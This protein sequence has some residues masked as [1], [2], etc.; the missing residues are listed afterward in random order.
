LSTLIIFLTV[1][2]VVFG[3]GYVVDRWITPRRRQK[4]LDRI[5]NDVRAG[6]ATRRREHHFTISS[7]SAGFVVT[8]TKATSENPVTM[9]WEE[10]VRIVAFKQD[11]FTTDCVCLMMLRD[12]D[13]GVQVDE[14]M[15]GWSEFTESLPIHLPGC[16]PWADWFMKITTPAF[17]SNETE[18]FTRLAKQ[19]S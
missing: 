16:R 2:A 11:L 7:D 14:E 9:T 6:K 10:V 19:T 15:K 4:L 8:S 12:D 3:V 5:I 17:A 1:F 13:N 18:I